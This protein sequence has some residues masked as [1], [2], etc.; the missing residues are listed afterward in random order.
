MAE[1]PS[2]LTPYRV[3]YSERVREELKGLL[4]RARQ[5]GLG[6]QV[7]A[8]VKEMDRRLRVYP[9]FG[10]PLRDLKLKPAQL[11]I[12]VVDPLVVQY[13]VDDDRRLVIVVM[14]ISTLPNAGLDP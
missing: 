3:S 5:R 12:G 6:P 4:S 8:A 1:P 14:P 7:L 10:Q 13:S 11:W 2:A 9:Q